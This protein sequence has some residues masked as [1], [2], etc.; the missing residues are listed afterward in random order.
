[1]SEN[2]ALNILK[3]ALN[4][5]FVTDNAPKNAVF[6]SPLADELLGEPMKNG[7]LKESFD[8]RGEAVA[9]NIPG[10]QSRRTKY[11]RG[12]VPPVG[13]EPTHPFGYKILSLARLPI[14]PQ[15]H[16]ADHSRFRLPKQAPA[17]R[18]SRGR[19]A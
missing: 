17:G 12:L 18:Q 15:G 3:K 19:G 13:L 14:P 7:A 16:G 9:L 10:R 8:V 6:D 11:Q 2:K 1:M 5:F 4:V